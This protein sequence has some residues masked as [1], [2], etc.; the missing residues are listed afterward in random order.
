MG[1]AAAEHMQKDLAGVP[2][3]KT[4]LVLVA[5][6]DDSIEGYKTQVGV[7]HKVDRS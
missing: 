4:V 2:A 6:L 5:G 7:V 1:F 3:V